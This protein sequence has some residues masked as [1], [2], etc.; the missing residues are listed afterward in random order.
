MRP[1]IACGWKM[2]FTSSEARAY[3]GTLLPMLDGIDGCDLLILPPFTSIWVARECLEGTGILWGAQD[4][5]TEDFGAHTGDVSAPMLS[6]LGCSFVEVGHAE[7]RRDYGETNELIAAKVDA[8][9][10]W[11]MSPMLCVGEEERLPLARV[12]GHLKRQLDPVVNRDMTGLVIAYEPFWAI[13]AGST[14][15][16]AEWV[17]DVHCSI[18]ELLAASAARKSETR[19]IYGG[20]VDPTSA[21]NLLERRGVDGLGIGRQSLDPN[22]L[23]DIL[24]KTSRLGSLSQPSPVRLRTTRLEARR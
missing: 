18:H 23:T 20:S 9:V 10:R 8:I 16:D 15:A 21:L 17:E 3:L 1:L 14:A 4:V 11:G 6:D 12:I 19:V 7:R 22:V 13:G 2:N 5:H 24:R